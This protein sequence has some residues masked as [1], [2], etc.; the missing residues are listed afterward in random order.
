M[1]QRNGDFSELELKYDSLWKSQNWSTI[2]IL[3][4]KIFYNSF[5]T[6][7]WIQEG[8][9]LKRTSVLNRVLGKKRKK[10]QYSLV[11]SKNEIQRKTKQRFSYLFS[12]EKSRKFRFSPTLFDP[13]GVKAGQGT[14][15]QSRENYL[16]FAVSFNKKQK[17]LRQ[18]IFSD[19]K[20]NF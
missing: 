10:F 8:D 12:F 1:E 18:K 9:S 15:K 6:K 7:F 19:K 13:Y 2:W 20:T 11:P 4:G 3:S 5:D 16:N 17:N 14:K